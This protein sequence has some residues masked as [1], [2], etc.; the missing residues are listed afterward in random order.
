MSASSQNT[1]EPGGIRWAKHSPLH[2]FSTTRGETVIKMST[3]ETSRQLD[4][5]IVCTFSKCCIFENLCILRRI[6]F[7]FHIIKCMIYN[8][9]Y[10]L[11]FLTYKI[12]T[13]KLIIVYKCLYYF[14]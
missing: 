4:K 11:S 12:V 7:V 13:F 14:N 8:L 5:F 6:C 1:Q 3:S 10:K 2:K 9:N